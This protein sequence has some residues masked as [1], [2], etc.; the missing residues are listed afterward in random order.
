MI[1]MRFPVMLFAL[2]ALTTALFF[3]L[4]TPDASAASLTNRSPAIENSTYTNNDGDTSDNAHVHFIRKHSHGGVQ[5][6]VELGAYYTQSAVNSWSSTQKIRIRPGG[7]AAEA[8]V[9]N[10]NTDGMT[11]GERERF[12]TVTIKSSSTRVYYIPASRVCLAYASHSNAAGTTTG[13]ADYNRLFADYAIPKPAAAQLNPF[14]N[15]YEVEV[16]VAYNPAIPA[17]DN[18]IRL[19]VDSL[20]GAVI[21]P[22]G[23]SGRAFPLLG[24]YNIWQYESLNTTI[25]VPFG[26]CA[27]TSTTQNVRIRLY[28]A[29]NGVGGFANTVMA[30]VRKADGTAVNILPNTT[31][32]PRVGGTVQVSGSGTQWWRPN[33]GTS[34]E[35]YFY[36]PMTTNTKYEFIVTGLNPR[37][38]I[39]VGLPTDSIFGAVSCDV[40]LSELTPE[41]DIEGGT[42]TEIE[43][44]DTANP[45]ASVDNSGATTT[46]TWERYFWY[47]SSSGVKSEIGR[48]GPA[49]KSFVAGG[50]PLINTSALRSTIVAADKAR[51]CTSLVLSGY[52]VTTDI[53]GSNP[54]Y[55]CKNIVRKPYLSIRNGDINTSCAAT[56]TGTIDAFWNPLVL[57]GGNGSGTTL[58]AYAGGAVDGFATAVGRL[59]PGP[60]SGLS[61]AN[62]GVG[63]GYG[64]P[65]SGQAGACSSLPDAATMDGPAGDL[66]LGSPVVTTEVQN[67]GKIFVKGNLTIDGNLAYSSASTSAFNLASIPYFEVIVS[68]NIYIKS[69]VTL[70]DGIYRAGGT[71]YTCTLASAAPVVNST[72]LANCGST[73]S[74]N[75]AFQAKDIKYLRLG[76][77]TAVTGSSAEI[78]TYDPLVWLRAVRSNTSGSAGSGK[79]DAYTTMPP[80]L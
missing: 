20:G 29:D 70:L 9:C 38:T 31:A 46:A 23:G 25:K 3:T 62:E 5:L 34:G 79:F 76:G 17:G 41:V 77:T 19:V 68:G 56:D 60:V 33:D 50:N 39:D 64:L 8:R 71:I 1:R 63:D 18:G 48:Q 42:S 78:F 52:P 4:Q 16:T 43:A 6:S 51:I 57:G 54:T 11:T 58:A 69:N 35:T 2:V 80:I 37:N 7:S 65:F 40:T 49:S 14:T 30:R 73:L 15:R 74:I 75:G 72:L 28:D 45:V 32:T 13:A 26:R 61:F 47:E 55:V 53:I 10:K 67:R 59:S 12:I 21:G 22:L 27:A 36:V 24:N 66:S 44:G